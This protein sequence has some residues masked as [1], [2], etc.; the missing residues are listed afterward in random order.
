MIAEPGQVLVTDGIVPLRFI[1]MA[2]DV[3]AEQNGDAYLFCTARNG[4]I[5]VKLDEFV[6][7]EGAMVVDMTKGEIQ[8]EIGYWPA[9]VADN[10][11]RAYLQ[12]TGAAEFL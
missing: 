11:R 6:E 10:C 2:T 8:E 1:V 4:V 12:D 7:V 9:E 5:S 3:E